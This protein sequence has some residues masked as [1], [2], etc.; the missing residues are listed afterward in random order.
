M[1]AFAFA[2]LVLP[3]YAIARALRLP[4]P[5]SASFPISALLLYEVVVVF[6]LIGV[7]VRFG[8]VFLVV[9][10]LMGIALLIM[11][12]SAT[13]QRPPSQPEPY[14]IRVLRRAVFAVVGLSLIGL[15]ILSTLRPLSGPDTLFRWDA[16]ARLMF[17]H[18]GLA[19]YPPVSAD[20][21]TEYFFPDGL[22]PLTSTL[23]WWIYAAWGRPS[24]SL[25]SP[26]IVLQAA[27]C[28]V[29]TYHAARTLHGE[30]GGPVAVAVLSC[31]L[32]HY[33][34]AIGQET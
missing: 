17:E 26:I 12:R 18:Q 10:V 21:F 8:S 24:P 4:F 11:R 13:H 29:L 22:P 9:G 34:V 19:H 2:G 28:F 32:F 33:G 15:F 23:Y 27:S 14:R 7:P 6:S 25:T 16:L 31:L 20:D 1:I 3:G 5:G 30:H